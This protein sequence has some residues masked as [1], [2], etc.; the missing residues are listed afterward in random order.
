MEAFNAFNW[1]RPAPPGLPSTTGVN[2]TAPVININNP[3]FG[4]YLAADDPRIMQFA[5]KYQF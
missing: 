3:N 4:R 2:A 1:F 5:I